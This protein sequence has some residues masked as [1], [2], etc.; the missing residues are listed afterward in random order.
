MIDKY[1][2][3]KAL[4]KQKNERK[5]TSKLSDPRYQGYGN[6]ILNYNKHY[7][8]ALFRGI[9]EKAWLIN[10]IV[11]HIIDKVS[12]YCRPMSARGSRGFAIE[13]KDEKEKMTEK[14]QKRAQEIQEFF[15]QTGWENA[16]EHEDDLIHYTRKIL[17]DELVLDQT[18]SEKLFSRGNELLSFEAVDAATILRCA[19]AGYDGNDEIRF[20]Q[21][22][23]GQVVT[24]YQQYQML[25][26]YMNARTD[27][28][29]YGYGYSKVEQTV[30]LVLALINSFNFNAG[31]FTD[32]KLPRGMLLLNGDIGVEEVEQLE[33]YLIDV[34]SP[35]GFGGAVSKYGIPIIPTG[36]AGDKSSIT[37]Q[38]LGSSNQ[39]MQFSRWQD[40]LYMATGAVYGVDIESMGIKIEKSAKIIES[41]SQ[42]ARRYSDDKGIGNALT[43]LER[44]FQHYLDLIDPRFRFVFH[45]FEQDDAK[46]TQEKTKSDLET[47]KSL[48]EIRV[49]NDLKKH[50]EPW[51]DVP[52]IQNPQY[53][54]AYNAANQ[55][56]EAQGEE[57][58]DD[59]FM[60]D[61]ENFDIGKSLAD[62]RFVIK[63]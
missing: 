3:R 53:L 24:Q 62:N 14:D 38:Q 43:F 48:N 35:N 49:E 2:F 22:L 8:M 41:G 6:G 30:D 27:V 20:V 56:E 39:D 28:A 63:I 17:R 32:D 34:M 26:Q 55:P 12:P 58:S 47:Y 45:G 29:H 44:H 18:T 36:K 61:D 51:A 42:S 54:Q 13:L 59:E 23:Q 57:Q 33:E 31:V 10:T 40:T 9:A 16:L 21:I 25:F 19:E 11:G 7:S 1:E 15:L 46:Q 52:G 5:Y 4:K 60:N 37:W 50:D